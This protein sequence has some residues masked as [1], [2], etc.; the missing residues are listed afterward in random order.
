MTYAQKKTW[1]IYLTVLDILERYIGVHI[2]NIIAAISG[3][4][5][6][7][8]PVWS[9]DRGCL[10]LL[11]TWSHL[12]YI[13]GSVLDHLF[14]WFVFPTCILKQITLWYPSHFISCFWH[15]R[16]LYW[17]C[18]FNIIA[19]I[20]GELF[21]DA[22]GDLLVDMMILDLDQT[23]GEFVVCTLFLYILFSIMIC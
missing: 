22:K 16:T 21:V 20:S 4:Y 7:S 6:V 12:W 17:C 10:L 13:R 9:I 23:T 18:I 2:F 1:W 5:L 8:P 11:G 19:A 15:P 14:L 3:N